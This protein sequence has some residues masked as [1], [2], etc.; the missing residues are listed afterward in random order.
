VHPAAGTRVAALCTMAA[1]TGCLVTEPIAFEAD[2]VPSHLTN[3][4]PAPFTRVPD[5]PEAPCKG[6]P[7]LN[8]GP[9]MPFTADI[10]D[11]N[12]SETLYVRLLING[13]SRGEVNSIP[14][15]GRLDRDP[16]IVCARRED[17]LADCNHVEMVVTSDVDAHPDDPEKPLDANE[18]TK[19]DW[20]VLPPAMMFPIAGQDACSGLVES[21]QQ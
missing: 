12:I 11:V 17:L 14:P 13:R 19:V 3:Q 18:Y 2:E 15:T 5:A 20:W 21:E 9:W 7:G 6:N 4:R 16:K 8:I 10:T 1:L